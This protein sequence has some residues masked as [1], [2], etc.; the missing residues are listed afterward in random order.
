MQEPQEGQCDSR[1]TQVRTQLLRL[2]DAVNSISGITKRCEEK[3]ASVL[4]QPIPE[5]SPEVANEGGLCDLAS[6]LRDRADALF[7]IN[8]AQDRIFDRLEL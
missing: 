5:K 7:D 4:T 6:E 2:K 8:A 3:L 1:E